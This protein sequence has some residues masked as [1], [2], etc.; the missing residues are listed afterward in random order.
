[1][2]GWGRKLLVQYKRAQKIYKII[3]LTVLLLFAVVGAYLLIRSRAAIPTA[4]I[5]PESGTVVSPAAKTMESSASG[6]QVVRFGPALPSGTILVN[7]TFENLAAAT[8][9]S[10]ADYRT[11]MGDSS[12]TVGT[13]TVQNTAI[14]SEPGHGKFMRQTLPANS[15][16]GGSGIVT[17]PGLSQTVDEAT[18]QYDVRFDSDFD[19]S[20]GGKLPGLGGA[21]TGTNPG[22]AAGCTTTNDYSWSGRGMWITPGSYPGSSSSPNEWI[23]YMY[24][25]TRQNSCGDNIQTNRSFVAGQWHTIKQYYKLNTPGQANGVHRMWLD[26]VQVVN[27]TNSV[28]RTA[29]DVH[30]NYIFWAVFRGGG[31]S[32]TR[33]QSPQTDS[34]DFDNLLIATP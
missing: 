6:G 26:G 32:D 23:G 33:W 30:I 34:I 19:W 5:E 1:M 7:T 4:S 17:F 2:V 11:A 18:I 28:Y 10:V 24:N 13:S 20:Y 22:D 12:F 14:L 9:I 8:P 31:A 21:R 27:A 15:S 29:T 25:P 3:P 16:G